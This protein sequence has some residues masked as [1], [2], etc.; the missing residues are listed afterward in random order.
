M[1]AEAEKIIELFLTYICRKHGNELLREK[2][3]PPVKV[4]TLWFYA[5]SDDQQSK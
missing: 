1:N 3:Q 2:C 5:R 4:T